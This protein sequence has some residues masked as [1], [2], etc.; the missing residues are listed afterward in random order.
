[1]LF[2]RLQQLR[3][4]HRRQRQR[5]E[6][7][8]DDGPRQR[9]GEFAKQNAGDAGD[10]ADRRID[11]GERDGH[12]DDRQRDLVRAA[13]RRVER[14]HALLDVAV[15]V[16]HHDN[17]VVDHEADA[18]HERQQRQKIDRIAERHQRDHHPDQR[19]RDG[20]DRNEGRPQIA[21]EKEDHDDHDRRRF[22]SVFATS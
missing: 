6:A 18:E 12:G 4:H 5:D 9:E 2:S 1:M 22:A 17:C 7:G 13:D 10:K 15:N 3:A 16:L 20:D 21:E 11:R 19:K 8:H 14:R